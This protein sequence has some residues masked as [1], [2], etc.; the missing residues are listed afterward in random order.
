VTASFVSNH[1]PPEKRRRYCPDGIEQ[2]LTEAAVQLAFA[3]YILD[4]PQGGVVVQMYPD[5]E[6]AKRFAIPALHKRPLLTHMPVAVIGR[7]ARGLVVAYKPDA[8]R[9][10]VFELNT[11]AM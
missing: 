4:H 6:H 3:L 1:P 8:F 11:A 10:G 5:G 9:M 2:K 7:L